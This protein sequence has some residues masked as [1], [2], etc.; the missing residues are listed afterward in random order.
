MAAQWTNGNAV[1]RPEPESTAAAG[2]ELDDAAVGWIVRWIAIGA[3][4]GALAGGLKAKAW[5]LF[6]WDLHSI[7]TKWVVFGTL[8]GAFLT[9]I[10]A[11]GVA[12]KVTWRRDQRRRRSRAGGSSSEAEAPRPRAVPRAKGRRS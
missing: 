4:L 3:L 1:T 5:W 12:Q 2:A 6:G 9:G 11:I 7:L 10:I 8:L